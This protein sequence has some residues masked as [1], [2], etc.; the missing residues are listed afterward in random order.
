MGRRS[1]RNCVAVALG[2]V[3]GV[4]G[5]TAGASEPN[6]QWVH[7]TQLTGASAVSDAIDFTTRGPNTTLGVFRESGELTAID[8]DGSF[9]GNGR[10]SALL[11][12]AVNGDGSLRF[13]ASGSDDLDFDGQ[14][15]SSGGPHVEEGYFEAYITVY[16]PAGLVIAAETRTAT[17]I[18][19]GVADFSLAAAEW[20]GGTADVEF[21]NFFGPASD[22]DF[23]SFVGL[24]TNARFVAEITAGDFDSALGLF[25]G[26]GQLIDADDDSGVGS[27]S[28]LTGVVPA[29]GTVSLAVSGYAD[30]GFTG[31]HSEIGAYTLRI[32]IVPEP[33]AGALVA[34]A[35]A[36]FVFP[37]QSRGGV[38][39]PRR[40]A[41]RL[42]H[43]R[44]D[45]SRR[46]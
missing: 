46:G 11:E 15:D 45:R 28:R 3:V 35:L 12:I 27:L 1:L 4:R 26:A 24:P 34:C 5:A 20:A 8:D 22:V 43:W 19:G 41:S 16:S 10:A 31:I 17:L 44:S 6:D 30:F 32:T 14:S 36:A 21:N 13:K 37:R 29:S 23:W 38:S 25:D 39:Q 7:A 9:F 18:S 40:W 2:L 42:G 33:A